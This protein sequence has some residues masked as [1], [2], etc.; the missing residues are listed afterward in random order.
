[1]SASANRWKGKAAGLK[2][3]ATT[4]GTMAEGSTGSCKHQTQEEE[5]EDVNQLLWASG[6]PDP[7]L[8]ISVSVPWGPRKPVFP[9]SYGVRPR[10]L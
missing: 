10:S 7:S 3:A 5:M 4:E 8:N 6:F 9:P 1:V 2:A